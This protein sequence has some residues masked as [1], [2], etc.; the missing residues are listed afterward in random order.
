MQSTRRRL[1]QGGA[2]SALLASLGPGVRL[3][4]G[5]PAAT[6]APVLIVLTC[7]GGQD[8]LSLVAPTEDPSLIAARTAATRLVSSGAGAAILLGSGAGPAA[9]PG[10]A[11]AGDDW[12]IHRG[13]PELAALYAAG[14]LAIVHATGSISDSRSH[15]DMTDRLEAGAP[16]LNGSYAAS[17]GWIGRHLAATAGAGAGLFAGVST[18]NGVPATFRGF[19]D[20]QY[21]PNVATFDVATARKHS[22]ARAAALA[23]GYASRASSGPDALLRQGASDTLAAV[24]VFQ[25]AAAGYAPGADMFGSGVWPQEMAVVAELVKM[26]I[27]VQVVQ[28]SFDGWDTHSGQQG[29]FSKTVPQLSQAI[30]QLYASLSAAGVDFTLVTM[31]EFGRRV[32]ENADGGTDHGH[33]NL[34]LVAGPNVRGGRILGR[35]PGL[36][37]GSLIYGDL[38]VTTENRAVLAEILASRGR[39]VAASVFPGLAASAPLGL[40]A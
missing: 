31:T 28:A 34:M 30:S 38:R 14:R 29:W 22:P 40:Y 16:S 11:A 32:A 37:P 24:A 35:W 7:L 5:A 9:A 27:G 19:R 13:A 15:A 8:G 6:P 2:I 20:V 25:A 18:A 21:L 26:N 4:F 1:I 39:G 3:G 12:H 23:A 17:T 10:A 33:A 36:S